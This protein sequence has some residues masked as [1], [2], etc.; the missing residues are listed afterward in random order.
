MVIQIL[1]IL[2]ALSL[3]V[4]QQSGQLEEDLAAF[5][6]SLSDR[7]ASL[8]R[9]SVGKE[10]KNKHIARREPRRAQALVPKPKNE[11]TKVIDSYA[12]QKAKAMKKRLD[13]KDQKTGIRR[14]G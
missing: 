11:I 5:S 10:T 6:S 7:I 1:F 9:S 14:R 13:V 4:A 8:V 12:Q 3:T 2:F